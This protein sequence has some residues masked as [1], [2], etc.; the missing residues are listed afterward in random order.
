MLWRGL[1]RAGAVVCRQ[2]RLNSGIVPCRTVWKSEK[3]RSHRLREQ[4]MRGADLDLIISASI[5][6]SLRLKKL[7]T[8]R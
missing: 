4:V 1:L 8:T 6:A 2:R 5:L 3:F 7:L